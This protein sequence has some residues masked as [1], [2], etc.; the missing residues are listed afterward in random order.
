MKYLAIGFWADQ[1]SNQT[2]TLSRHIDSTDARRVVELLSSEMG[3][4][5]LETILLIGCVEDKPTVVEFWSAKEGDFEF[6]G[7][8]A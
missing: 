1:S 3:I 2:L 4:A 5:C 8:G 7:A 6:G